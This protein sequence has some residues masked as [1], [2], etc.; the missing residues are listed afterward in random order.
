M[1]S[2][3]LLLYRLIERFTSTTYRKEGELTTKY[4]ELRDRK[5]VTDYQI[6][7]ET[8][9]PRSTLSELAANKYVSKVDKLIKL[10]DYFG[11]SVE[12]LMDGKKSVNA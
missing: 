1:V 9:I 2:W 5:G 12:E 8:G 3:Q 11:V 6:S 7:K 4:K 10:A